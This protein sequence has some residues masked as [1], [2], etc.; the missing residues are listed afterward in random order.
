MPASSPDCVIRSRD[1]TW[2][3]A[4]AQNG[5][6]SSHDC[7]MLPTHSHHRHHESSSHSTEGEHSHIRQIRPITPVTPVE[8]IP[9]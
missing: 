4:F 9:S 2:D 5:L 7:A 8:Y 6:V 3:K 1:T